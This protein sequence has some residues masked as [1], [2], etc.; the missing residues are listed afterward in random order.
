MRWCHWILVASIGF[1]LVGCATSRSEIKIEPQKASPPAAVG[2]PA[3]HGAVVIRSITDERAFQEAPS[4]PSIPSLGFGGAAG[5]TADVKARAIGRKRGSFGKA[6]GDVLLENGQTVVGVMRDTVV[7]AFQDA[8]FAVVEDG[9]EGSAAATPVDVHIKQ[10]WAWFNP[11]FW[12][13][14]LSA[15]VGTDVKIGDAPALSVLTHAE[16]SRQMATD[17]AWMEIIAKGLE[18]YRADLAA[19]LKMLPPE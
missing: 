9:H 13:I 1:A 15:N 19:K 11:G 12:A 6:F 17:S 3:S 5:A 4:D 7:A 14:T 16:D 8:G 10:C 18:A 2:V